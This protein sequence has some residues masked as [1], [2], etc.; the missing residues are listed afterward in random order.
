MTLRDPS[1]KET[2]QR[3]APMS[4]KTRR[5]SLPFISVPSCRALLIGEMA[6]TAV[7]SLAILSYQKSQLRLADSIKE[8]GASNPAEFFP[9]GKIYVV[10]TLGVTGPMP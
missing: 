2:T 9:P 5:A 7:Y 3:E 6:F 10:P 8:S 1:Q 4:S